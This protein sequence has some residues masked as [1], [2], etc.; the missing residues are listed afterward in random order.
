MYTCSFLRFIF[1]CLDLLSDGSFRQ[2]VDNAIG[3]SSEK[4]LC[5]LSGTADE[6]MQFPV[7]SGVGDSP[8]RMKT[9]EAPELDLKTRKVSDK[10]AE[11]LGAIANE[12]TLAMYR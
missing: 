10:F 5:W 4:Q 6:R 3:L 11:A 12:P 2:W 9:T 8:R 7:M 1:G